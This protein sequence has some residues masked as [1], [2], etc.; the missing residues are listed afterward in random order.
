MNAPTAMYAPAAR[1]PA[2][3]VISNNAAAISLIKGELIKNVIVIPN[4]IP[5]AINAINNGIEEQEQNGVTTPKN[6]ANK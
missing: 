5:A 3:G 1:G 4:G 2:L 6:T